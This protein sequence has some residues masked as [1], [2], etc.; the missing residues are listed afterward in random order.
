MSAA[1]RSLGARSRGLARRL[2]RGR[3]RYVVGAA[4]LAVWL[5]VALVV[6]LATASGVVWF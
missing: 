5:L 2:V 6:A 3:L 1:P 4:I